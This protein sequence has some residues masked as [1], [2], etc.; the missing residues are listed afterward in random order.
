M[1]EAFIRGVLQ[2]G[3]LQPAQLCVVSRNPQGR[4]VALQ[5]QYGVRAGSY[6]QAAQARLV[7]LAVKPG[8]AADALAQVEPYLHG[9]PLVSFAAG[10]TMRWLEE[11]V[12]GK[13][14]VVRT[15]PNLPVAVLAGVTAVAFPEHGLLPADRAWIRFLLEQLGTVVEVPES[16]MDAVTAV[17]GSGPGFVCAFLEAMEQTAQRLGMDPQLARPLLLQT[18]AGTAQALREWELSPAELRQRVASP[19]GTTQAGLAVFERG[20]LAALVSEALTAAANRS[21]ELGQ[22]FV[23]T[24]RR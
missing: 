12:Q 6:A 20:G 23:S 5:G 3:A 21:A 18:L 8:D 22:A 13:S 11:Q 7:L 24:G 19:G 15:M 4:A 1:A 17:S 9:Q 2:R 16:L 10:V 14:P